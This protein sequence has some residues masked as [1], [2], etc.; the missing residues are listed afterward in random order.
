MV[1]VAIDLHTHTT[2]SDGTLT[3]RELVTL[4][5]SKGFR[6]LSITDHDTVAGFMEARGCGGKTLEIVPGIELNAERGSEEIHVLGYYI[7]VENPVLLKRLG[8]LR[9]ERITRVHEI[10][11]RLAALG[12]KVTFDEIIKYARGESVGRPHVAR[13]LIDKGYIPDM[14]YAFDHFLKHGGKAYVPRPHFPPEEAVEIIAASGGIPVLAHPGYNADE[15]IIDS[16]VE[17]GLKGIEVFYP[18]HL[19]LQ[20][21]HFSKLAGKK[22]LLITGGSDF[23]GFGNSHFSSLGVEGLSM[24]HFELLKAARGK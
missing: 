20:R 22:G 15:R 2:A 1:P 12:M 9:E 11:K 14:Q 16:L 17:R 13:L 5:M 19:P 23:H 7:D 8:K 4:A 21:E 10:V 3:P 24:K 18:D 6:V